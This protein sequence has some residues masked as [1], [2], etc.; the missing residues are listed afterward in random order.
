MTVA[1][2]GAVVLQGCN[3]FL[4]TLPTESYGD[5]VVWSSAS[6]VEA[7]VTNNYGSAFQWYTSSADWDFQF[8]NNMVGR[9]S[10]PNPVRGLITN[11]NDYGFANRFGAIRNCNIIIERVT[12]SASLD[13]SYKTRFI[14]EAKFMRAMIYY[15]QARKFGRFMWVD[16]VLTPEDDLE[17]PV[18]K[19]I[20]ESYSYVLKDI[21]DAAEGLPAS[22]PAGRPTRNA[23]LALL[24]EACL[25][26]AAYTNND[27]S[28]YVSSGVD[29]Y[30]EAINAVDA[31]EGKS[32]VSAD[33]FEDMFNQNGAYGSPE[34][35]LARYYSKD[36]RRWDTTGQINLIPNNVNANNAQQHCDTFNVPD[37]FEGWL[38]YTPSQN[39]VDDFLVVDQSTGKAVRWYES[40][41]F[42][43]NVEASN[44]ASLIPK[45][46]LDTI[47]VQNIAYYDREELSTDYFKV[48]KVTTDA[49]IDDLMYNH[50]DARFDATIVHDGSTWYGEDIKMCYKGNMCR[51]SWNP[52]QNYATHH[53]PLTNYALRKTVYTN[54]SPRP[55]YDVPTDF[56]QVVFR[57]GRALLNKAE[58]QL[59]KNDI[60]GAVATLNMTRTTHGNL[61]AS[62]ASTAAEAWADYKIERRVELVWE[63]DWYFSLLRW[64]KYGGDANDGKAADGIIDELTEPVTFI[65]IGR[66]HKIAYVAPVVRNDNMQRTFN[67]P[68]AYLLPI[69]RN[70]ILA[71]PAITDADQNPGW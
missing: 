19:S 26:A 2:A 28:L 20:T 62:T 18:T 42:T 71:N 44:D 5:D 70:T 14:A 22:A 55:F 1:V 30:Q 27:S 24:S 43:Q 40:S 50:R 32:L 15:D 13:E 35:I 11:E 4:D 51:W 48:Y 12:E 9:Q 63:S 41:Q 39:L 23:A 56:H 6:N 36:T 59:R 33:A 69:P 49:D 60:A 8:S 47:P 34:I 54:A 21:R 53:T 68:R 46:I 7:F 67:A 58:A 25:T 3:D 38:E 66:D 45:T 16:K 37:I 65:E 17:I 57:Y 29:L 10:T 52:S 64:G 31:I 61:P